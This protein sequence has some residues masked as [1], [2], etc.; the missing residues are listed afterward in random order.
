[1]WK[2]IKQIDSCKTEGFVSDGFENIEHVTFSFH[3]EMLLFWVALMWD[4]EG[5]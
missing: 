2:Q 1:M 5:I 4:Q 3:T